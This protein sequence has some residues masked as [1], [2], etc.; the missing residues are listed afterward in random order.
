MGISCLGSRPGNAPLSRL[1]RLSLTAAGEAQNDLVQ[2]K[3]A[4]PTMLGRAAERIAAAAMLAEAASGDGS[5]LLLTGEAGIGKTTVL[6]AIAG[7]AR[8]RGLA[9][10]VAGTPADPD[11]AALSPWVQLLEEHLRGLDGEAVGH[12]TGPAASALSLLGLS[13]AAGTA[14]HTSHVG[15]GGRRPG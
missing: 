10:H 6:H 14:E 2:S 11:R 7:E 1:A 8:R 13:N 5:L 12:I 15:G 9:V 3:Y 4:G